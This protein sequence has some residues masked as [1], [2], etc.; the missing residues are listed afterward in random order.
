MRRNARAIIDLEALIHN[1][2]RVRQLAPQSKVMAVIKADAYGHGMVQVAETLSKAGVDGFAVA[3]LSEARALREAGLQQPITVFQGFQD[4]QQLQQMIQLNLRPVVHQ[5]WQID[6]LSQ[7]KSKLS[8]WLKVNSGMGR[9]GLPA[10]DIVQRW[11]SLQQNTRL[12]NIGLF[13]HFAN[14]DQP[15]HD[16]NKQQIERFNSL[17]QSLGV[18]ETSMANSAG[19]IA[20]SESQGDW[21]RPGIMLYGSSPLADKSAHELAL[22]PVMQLE[23]P[24]L[25]INQMKKG[26]S[27]GY[28]SLWQCPDDMPVGVVGIGY[29]DGY[30]R[31][32]G[33]GTPVWINGCK[34]QLV[35]RVSMDMISIDLRNI[36]A[37]K[38]G[39][40]V[41][42]W[43]REIAV[44]EI[45]GHAQTI[46]YE[47]LCHMNGSRIN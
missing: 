9:L 44:D 27:I 2:Q 47:L 29:G 46:A 14:A 23:A 1:Y 18:T 21:V 10:E 7:I 39:D 31:H 28:G 3:C 32:A 11:P 20:F 15:E 34:T 37:V 8:I 30:P 16:S 6:L 41:V 42:L 4:A 13:S 36:E 35:G 12:E 38:T 5:S 43:G 17:A 24:L 25:A 33:T 45:A 40:S 26:E 19:L 22:K